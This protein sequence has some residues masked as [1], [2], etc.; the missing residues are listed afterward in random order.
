MNSVRYTWNAGWPLER[1]LFAMAGSFTLASVVLAVLLTPWIL[2]FTAFVALNQ[3][4]YAS[5][6]ACGTSLLLRRL[7]PLKPA[8]AMTTE[9]TAATGV[10]GAGA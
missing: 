10:D 4:L 5:V 3:L 8:C 2:A 7:T 6:G 1:V 9:R